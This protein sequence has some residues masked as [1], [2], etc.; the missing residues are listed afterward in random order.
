[1]LRRAIV[2]AAVL[3]L[4]T[5]VGAQEVQPGL[6]RTGV[7]MVDSVP[8]GNRFGFPFTR[9][10]YNRALLQA[11]SEEDAE[12]YA[13]LVYEPDEEVTG[14]T[15]ADFDLLLLAALSPD[16]A[17]RVTQYAPRLRERVREIRADPEA[18]R[19]V[20]KRADP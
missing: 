17:A 19:R 18:F 15:F 6:A 16:T 9:E 1:M 11:R 14:I 12:L 2:A 7:A 8:Y 13:R 10:E 4:S 5:G 3:A 20:L